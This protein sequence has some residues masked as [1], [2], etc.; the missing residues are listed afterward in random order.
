[1]KKIYS[2]V[3]LLFLLTF[4]TQQVSASAPYI[5]E[6]LSPQNEL[7]VTQTAYNPVGLFANKYSFG[8]IEDVFIDQSGYIF[9]VD[10]DLH[11]VVKFD[12]NGNVIKEIGESVLNQPTGIFVT[13]NEELFV[14]DYGLEEVVKFDS[15]G[16]VEKRYTT[17]D[18]PLFG[19]KVKYKPQKV[20][21]DQRGNLYVISEGSS[22]GI[23]QLNS[24]GGFLGFYGSNS[25]NQSFFSILQDKLFANSSKE[26]KFAKLPP[27][28]TNVVIDNQ[29]L[30]YSLTKGTDSESLKKLNVAGNNMLAADTVVKNNF[31][32]V[33]I[34]Q[35][36]NIYVIGNDGIVTVYD[37]YG[38]LLFQFGGKDDGTNRLGLLKQPSS[39]TI[40]NQNRLFVADRE[41]ANITI[42]EITNFGEKVL[43]GVSGL[44][45]GLYLESQSSW[46][47]VL[48]LND[49][50]RLAHTAMGKAYFQQEKHTEALNEFKLASDKEGYS[51]AFWQIRHEWMLNNLDNVLYAALIL[52]AIY[53]L[54]TFIDRRKN[55]LAPIRTGLKN[56]TSISLINKLF[57]LFYFIKNPVDGF[58]ELKRNNRVSVL[59]ATI[60]F[61]VAYIEIMYLQLGSGY[62]FTK[63]SESFNFGLTTMI[64]VGFVAL[65]I[66]MN[67]LVSTINNGEGKFAQVYMGTAY[68]MAPF[69]I[70]GFPI[71]IV[72][73][74]LTINE[75]FVY[76]F[77]L[78][79]VA[80]W[81][82][83][84]LFV[85][86]KELH[87]Y[88]ISETIR[89]VIGTLFAMIL[90][91]LVVLVLFLISKQVLDFVYSI[92]QEVMI[93][94]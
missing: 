53:M 39:I 54:I 11:K 9:V 7:I 62:I 47:D 49:S 42:F 21:V 43:A 69:I 81:S 19:K 85:M 28:P 88:S 34:D 52:A 68:S 87:N 44:K 58:Y 6:T 63:N 93:R 37:S 16:N 40:D 3:A 55:I 26:K 8:K 15:T 92:V 36:G 23:I 71:A 2:I 25:T 32:D 24:D 56:F 59:S 18:S 31:E 35:S 65:F 86:I 79:V 80:V 57:Y 89:N 48:R 73:K 4:G 70:A 84:I 29:G 1:M 38:N 45:E 91:V 33:A 50:F 41:N 90:T 14:A 20:S 75:A 66:V 13:E 61:I 83:V 12:Q 74:F 17:P 72:S 67:Y 76:D 10:S 30:V 22:N 27:A 94:V 60:L 64:I 51:D 5:T 77:S 78:Q 82:G 46:E